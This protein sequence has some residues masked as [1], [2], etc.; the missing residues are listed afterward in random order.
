MKYARL[1]RRFPRPGDLRPFLQMKQQSGS[2]AQRRVADAHTIEDLRRIARRRTPSGPFHYVDGGAEAEISMRRAREAFED[3]EFNPWILRDVHEVDT[4]TTVL[5]KS[6][7]LPF[8]F[9]PTGGTRMMHAAGESAVARAAE[10]AGIP[11][12]LSTVGTTSIPDLAAAAPGARRWF[13]MYLLSDRARSLRMLQAAER[14]GYDSLLVTVD[15]PVNG[16]R[17]RD[18]RTGMSY[19]PRLTPKTF[20]DA[21]YRVEWWVNLLTT[22]PYRFT[23]EEPGVA[24]PQRAT[25]GNFYDNS[26]TFEDLAWMREAWHGPIVIKGIQ[27]ISDAQRAADAGVDGIVLSNHGGRQLDRTLPPLHLLPAVVDRVGDA[28]EVMLDTG[29]R[30][31]ADVVAAIALGAKFVLVGRA[32]LYGLMAGGEAGVDR[33]V[34]ILRTEVVRT[35]QLLGVRSIDELCPEHVTLLSRLVR[36]DDSGRTA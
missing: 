24:R 27:T 30:T 33:A 21:S 7:A 29:V 31:G 32:Y 25:M 8:G 10:R 4:T 14:N 22:E 15:V 12:A 13:Q 16:N 36:F 2:R 6:S 28:V 20:V 19:P 3:L 18:L 23:F 5:G 26:V 34:E 11:Y 1:K 35:M 9:G 17:L